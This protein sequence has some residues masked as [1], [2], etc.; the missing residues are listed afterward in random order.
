MKKTVSCND[1]KL[2]YEQFGV[3]LVLAEQ[4]WLRIAE[5]EEILCA[6]CICKRAEKVNGVA[7]LA[8]ISIK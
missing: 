7:L 1:C 3:D 5:K 4:H 6:N 8:W 2:P